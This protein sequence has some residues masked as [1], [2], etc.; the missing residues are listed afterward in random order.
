MA[1][2]SMFFSCFTVQA[3]AEDYLYDVSSSCYLNRAKEGVERREQ[4]MEE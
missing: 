1:C 4:I 2:I 3:F